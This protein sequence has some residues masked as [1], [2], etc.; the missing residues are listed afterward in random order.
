MSTATATSKRPTKP[1]ARDLSFQEWKKQVDNVMH[2]MCGL[3]VDDIPGNFDLKQRFEAGADI[4]QT[5]FD[6]YAVLE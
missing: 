2:Q 5:A 3:G 6:A 1:V 4:T